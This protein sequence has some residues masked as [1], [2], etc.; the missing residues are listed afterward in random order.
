MQYTI[1]DA[2]KSTS[3]SSKAKSALFDEEG[4]ISFGELEEKAGCF[5]GWLDSVGH[6]RGARVGI[7]LPKIREEVIATLGVA[8]ARGVF[9][10][11]NY[12]WTL[13]QLDFVRN[14]CNIRILVTDVRRAKQLVE[15]ALHKRFETIL[16]VGDTAMAGMSAWAEMEGLPPKYQNPLGADLA[17]LLYTSGS[18]GQ[19]KGVMLTHA[20]LL[21]GAEI[22]SDYLGIRESD[23]ILSVPPLSFDYGL[24][25]LTSCLLTGAT[26][27]LQKVAMP[28]TIAQSV[29]KWN[30]TGLP[31]VA[32]SWVQ[33]LSY[34]K[35]AEQTLDSVRYLTNTGGAIPKPTLQVM[36]EHLPNAQ[37]FLMY[38]LTEA[39]RSTFLPPSLFQDKMGAI[40]K[41]IPNVEIFVVNEDSGVCGPGE[42]GE[43]IHRGD[44]I[45]LGYWNRNEDT[46]KRIHENPHLTQL[47]GEEK[48]LHSGDIVRIDE[49]GI[50]WYV[51]R[52]DSMIKTSG[53]RVSPTEIESHATT[54]PQL[55]S[56]VA[57]GIPDDELGQVVQL[58]VVCDDPNVTEVDIILSLRKLL[59]GYM[60]PRRVWFW[61]DI[62]P[63][64]S[65]GKIDRQFVSRSIIDKI[66][67]EAS[68][69]YSNE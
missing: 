25:Q 45:S 24:N 61:E 21:R 18:T 32:P 3:I 4:E 40:G 53:H 33:L 67:N 11:L 57:L 41:A 51:G 64:T 19:P 34:L 47:I 37:I 65:S 12:Q 31:L 46:A 39:F 2:L 1:V 54:I 17:A 44:L 60:V 36:Q 14:D 48:V 20:M 63:M 10:N 16:V 42:S 38:G 26:L 50:L 52:N 68:G 27:A 66:L 55:K 59:P 58:V 69:D 15:A 35:D 29:K 6:T 9:V 30:I 22:V 13:Q 28:S 23:R 43:L 7:S 5:A 8:A 56:A 62:M 49:D